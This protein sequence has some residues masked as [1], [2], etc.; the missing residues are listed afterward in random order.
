MDEILRT[1]IFV[2]VVFMAPINLYAAYRLLSLSHSN[3][4]N[5]GALSERASVAA[6]LAVASTS[7]AILSVTRL[8]GH[9][10]PTTIVIILN[11]VAAILIGLPGIY[12]FIK[13]R[14]HG[15]GD[16]DDG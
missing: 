1:I 11:G 16:E 13:Y 6:M 3:D 8:L 10:L 4:G 7:G 14:R 5:I 15:F 12:W 9:P 2:A